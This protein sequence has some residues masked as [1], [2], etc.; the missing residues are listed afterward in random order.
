MACAP[1]EPFWAAAV[2]GLDATLVA[3]LAWW[4][5]RTLQAGATDGRELA[6]GW[7]VAAVVLVAGSAAL[8]GLV[9]GLG[10]GGFLAVHGLMAG[11]LL[12]GRRARLGADWSAA[13]VALGALPRA[14]PAPG[15][16]AV[17][18]AFLAVLVFALVIA[19][20]A[21]PLV[22]D[23]LT[24]RLPRIAHWLQEGRIGSLATDDARLN[25]MPVGPDLVVAW[26]LGASTVGYPLAG[27]AQVAGGVLLGGSTFEFARRTGLS[28]S[29]AAGAVAL[30]LGMGHVAPQLG[31]LHTDL[32]T[33]GVFA[34]SVAL[35]V[36]A[37]GRGEGSV[38]AG[39]GLGLALGSKGTMLY[40]LPALVLW[41]AWQWGV[42]RP[43][44]RA[45]AATAT[46]GI[47]A[48]LLFCVPLWARNVA[49]FGRFSG[50]DQAMRDH[51]GAPLGWAERAAKLRVNLR[52]AAIQACD[53]HSQPPWFRD[54]AERLGRRMLVGLPRHDAHVFE[55]SDRVGSLE[56]YFALSA[57]DA[58]FTGPGL[59][60]LAAFLF[61]TAFAAGP[62]W[63]HPGARE[64]RFWS[65]GVVSF[66]VAQNALFQWHPWGL[67][68]AVLV[69][70]WLGLVAAWG[71]ERLPR[72]LRLAGW[73]LLLAGAAW[74]F[75]ET[76]FRS[77]QAPWQGFRLALASGQGGWHDWSNRLQPQG[78]PLYLG[79]RV[80]SPAA[81]FF[82]TRSP[83]PVRFVRLSGLAG[84]TAE[85][86]LRSLGPGWLVV[87]AA[88]FMGR[89]GRVIASSWNPFGD[90]TM[91][92]SVVGYRLPRP[93]EAPPPVLY[94]DR[95]FELPAGFGR[96]LVLRAWRPEVIVLL[97]N[98]SAHPWR[99]R[100][101]GSHGEAEADL[102]PGETVEVPV[103]CASDGLTRL[104]AAFGPRSDAT[105]DGRV[106]VVR[107]L[108]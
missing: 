11:A 76:T 16:R 3:L 108:R 47:V 24:Y 106:P 79:L 40:L 73:T 98:P 55:D 28:R 65:A 39:A 33:A 60:V 54:I 26:L 74:V 100:L 9:G 72:P 77:R 2:F 22:F 95:G 59:A 8:L 15:S 18:G 49:E 50:P 80:N 64:V 97:A 68:Y 107:A 27:W 19:A 91:K 17:A 1:V 71:V 105:T 46:A 85:E 75:G 38:L 51:Y 36:R 21:V 4:L 52:S 83:R 96:A 82:R 23:A 62:G 32:F 20:V 93:E 43:S 90:E 67:R 87:P 101:A 6:L 31:S 13:R 41:A 45:V 53:P 25:Y 30:V 34:A 69:A 7:L 63:R 102:P 48:V 70:P 66:V 58:D 12:V 81:Q 86:A 61:A 92:I 42:L 88:A 44:W 10:R 84:G 29:A 89:E 35:A 104:T 94:S 99:V 5:V 56:L 103:G 14:W 57:P 78:S 37:L